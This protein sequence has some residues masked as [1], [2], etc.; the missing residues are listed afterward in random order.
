MI[1][2]RL[3]YELK[4]SISDFELFDNLINN[5]NLCYR[6]L[7]MLKNSIQNSEEYIKNWLFIENDDLFWDSSE[8]LGYWKIMI[9]IQDDFGKNIEKWNSL[10]TNFLISWDNQIN[11]NSID[12]KINDFAQMV[13][14]N[15]AFWNIIKYSSRIKN[16][17]GDHGM[18]FEFQDDFLIDTFF[19][20]IQN[21]NDDLILYSASFTNSENDSY[22]L[23]SSV[24]TKTDFTTKIKKENN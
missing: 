14:E 8:N 11:N 24:K 13:L 19:D 5:E 9:I 22:I 21:L 16:D 15:G 2:L 12:F 23:T 18:I 4:F 17:D 20:K 1:E 7:T 10:L 3:V 6:F